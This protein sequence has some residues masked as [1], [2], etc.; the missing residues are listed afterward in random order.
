MESTTDKSGFSSEGKADL[1]AAFVKAQQAFDVPKKT[2]TANIKSYSYKYSTLEDLIAATRPALTANGLA[3]FNN[4]TMPG[5]N[6]VQVTAIIVHVSG[7][8]HES[9]P[10]IFQVDGSP[11]SAGAAIT[12]GRRYTQSA[13]LGVA[14]EDDMDA[15]TDQRERNTTTRQAANKSTTAKPN[16]SEPVDPATADQPI[17]DAQ[18]AR[19]K[20]IVKAAGVK[21]ADM[22]AWLKGMDIESSTHIKRGQ[23]E[24]I[25]LAVQ[26]GKVPKAQKAADKK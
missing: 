2:K 16:D 15:Q 23:Y 4:V 12:Y 5:T 7:Q 22:G 17:T 21:G 14:A 25:V 13:L 10:V 1:F 8:S 18:I 19:L 3:V 20:R 24:N 9:D 26:N 6:V 11:Q